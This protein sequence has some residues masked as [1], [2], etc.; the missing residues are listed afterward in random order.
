M[1][2]VKHSSSG[3]EVDATDIRGVGLTGLG[4][5]VGVAI[6]FFLVYGI[7]HYLAHHPFI[8]PLAS[9]LA[10][11]EHQQF[12]NVPR[13]EEHPSIELNE[14]HLQENRVL[15]TYGWVDKSAGT[16]RIPIDQAIELQLKRGFP[17]R[18]EAA[19]K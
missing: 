11:T 8:V 15:S 10:E 19:A 17:V 12:P 16:I 1:E 7:F 5:T 13:I 2:H 14:L 6:V 9:P 3:H 4:L 18:K